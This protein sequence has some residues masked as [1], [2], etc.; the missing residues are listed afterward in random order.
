MSN[1]KIKVMKNI[2]RVDAG[3]SGNIQRIETIGWMLFLKVWDAREM[4]LELTEEGFTSPLINVRWINSEGEHLAED[5]RWRTWAA[6]PES[7]T[8]DNLRL[9]VNSELFPAIKGMIIP[10]KSTDITIERLRKRLLMIR[11]GFTDM[12]NYMTN[13]TAMRELINYIHAKYRIRRKWPKR[14]I[15]R[16]V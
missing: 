6:N 15:W 5:I 11:Q 8:G 1:A 9:F 14:C 10:P 3:V 7:I 16:F 12:N 4:D 2:M 13:G